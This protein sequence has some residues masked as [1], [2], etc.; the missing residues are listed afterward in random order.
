MALARLFWIPRGAA[1]IEGAYVAYPLDDLLAIVALESHRNRCLVIGE[2]LGTVP[3]NARVAL[4]DSGVLSYDVLYFE[5][6]A[7]GDFKLPD[8]YEAQSIAVATTHDLATLAGWWQGRDLELREALGLFPNE[9]ARERQLAARAEDRRRLLRA[10]DDSDLLPDRTG[11]DPARIPVMTDELARAIHVYLA[12]TPAKLAV[13][14]VDDI[15]GT[16]DQA[17]LPG[18]TSEHPNWRR[19]LAL[20]LEQFQHD[21]RFEAVARAMSF[22]RPRRND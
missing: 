7:S 15:I 2:D 22:E 14:Q 10:L 4:K 20:T 19:K 12:R 3:D 13:I 1:P 9:E 17:N 18:T 11:T 5:R 6:R 21:R 8:E 16:L